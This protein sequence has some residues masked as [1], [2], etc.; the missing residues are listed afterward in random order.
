MW[1]NTVIYSLVMGLVFL[2]AA[3]ALPSVA[4]LVHGSS[5]LTPPL[6]RAILFPLR[7]IL[8]EDR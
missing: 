5:H 3:L 2:A 8:E 7:S 1:R 4:A 6:A